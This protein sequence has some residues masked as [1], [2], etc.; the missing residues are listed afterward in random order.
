[1]RKRQANIVLH[2]AVFDLAWKTEK[3]EYEMEVLAWCSFQLAGCKGEESTDLFYT[4]DLAWLPKI[5]NPLEELDSKQQRT[6]Q[7]G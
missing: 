5:C 3:A 1:M 4:K 6:R 7:K 2:T